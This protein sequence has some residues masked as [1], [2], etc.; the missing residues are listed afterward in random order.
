MKKAIF[1]LVKFD[2]TQNWSEDY[3]KQLNITKVFTW[4]I[5]NS[6]QTT[7]CCE[8]L[9]SYELLPVAEEP[10]CTEDINDEFYDNQSLN[11]VDDCI[12]MHCNSVDKIAKDLPSE[13][14][15]KYRYDEKKEIDE[16]WDACINAV[17]NFQQGYMHLL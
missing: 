1:K 4:Y 3:L 17:V 12:Y 8:L 7:N 13:F 11:L 5:F 16:Y 9:P 6:L 2:T 15:V 14:T 10:E